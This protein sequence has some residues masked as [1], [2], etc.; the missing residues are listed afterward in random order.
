MPMRSDGQVE[1]EGDGALELRVIGGQHR[2]QQREFE[3]EPRG[4]VDQ[5]AQIFGQAG[6][7]EGE[8][9]LEVGGRDIERVVA[10]EGVHDFRAVDAQFAGQRADFV[11][12]GNLHRVE[13]VAGVLDHLCGAQGDDGGLHGKAGID[14]GDALDGLGRRSADHQQGGLHEVAYRGAFAQELGIGDHGDQRRTAHCGEHDSS[15]VP[16]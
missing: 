8:A 5:G 16:G 7:A 6:A 12:E 14:G 10:A 4:A 9:R 3:I 15:Q 2:F 13:G 11:G 1:S